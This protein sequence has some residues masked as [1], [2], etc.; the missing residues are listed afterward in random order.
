MSEVNESNDDSS[1]ETTSLVCEWLDCG[2]KF[3]SLD[4]LVG[5]LMLDHIKSRQPKYK[6]EW[7]NCSRNGIIQPSR[8]ALVSHV[9]KHT[10]EKPYY[11]IIPECDRKFTRSDALA[12]HIRTVH[13]ANRWHKFETYPWWY[14]PASQRGL[15][16]KTLEFAEQSR[17]RYHDAVDK[18]EDY[19]YFYKLLF[20]DGYKYYGEV[21]TDHDQELTKIIKLNERTKA[22]KVLLTDIL[23]PESLAKEHINDPVEVKQQL[24][25]IVSLQFKRNVINDFVDCAKSVESPEVAEEISSQEQFDRLKR[26]YLWNIELNNLLKS[27]LDKLVTEKKHLF[28]AKESLLEAN[29][30]LDS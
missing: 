12:K 22:K 20:A 18:T 13:D 21:K 5:H 9:R 17:K 28:L 1:P 26:Q 2:I 10:G 29:L 19:K 3:D 8:F 16:D 14:K 25:E 23:N 27:D 30:R 4:A 11:C 7:Q 15:A 6:C 24:S